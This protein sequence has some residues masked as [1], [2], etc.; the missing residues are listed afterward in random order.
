MADVFH[1][2][3]KN[4]I[5]PEEVCDIC[6]EAVKFVFFAK[7]EQVS[8]HVDGR[9]SGL[10]LVNDERQGPLLLNLHEAV[11][12]FVFGNGVCSI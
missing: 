11:F 5:F 9:F 12:V 10:V 6:C 2:L 4:G 3:P 8:G 7:D 1:V